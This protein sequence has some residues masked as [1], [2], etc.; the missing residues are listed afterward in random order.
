MR[1]ERLL[2]DALV[3]RALSWPTP[4]S[5]TSA[6]RKRCTCRAR[7]YLVDGLVGD[8]AD[9]DRTLETLRALF[10]MIEEKHRLVELLTHYIEIE[11]A[12]GRDRLGASRPSDFH[13]FSVVASTFQRRPA[14]PARSA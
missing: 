8:I 3:A 10:R 13:P 7:R 14:G 2:Y 6:P 5:Q 11:R 12:D 9:R 4:A 1:Q